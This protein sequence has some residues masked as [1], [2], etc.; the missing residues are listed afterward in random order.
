[1]RA[2]SRSRAA[3]RESVAT[4]AKYRA[5]RVRRSGDPSREIQENTTRADQPRR[6]SGM[7]LFESYPAPAS[8]RRAARRRY[9]ISIS[10]CQ[11]AQLVPATRWRPGF[12]LLPASAEASAGKPPCEGWAVR[13]QAHGCSGTRRACRVRGASALLARQARH[14]AGCL[15]SHDAGRAPIGAP[16]WRF[17]AGV[18]ASFPGIS[19]GSVQRSSSQPSRCAW[20]AGS[21]TSRACGYEPQPRDATP[22]SA[23]RHVSGRR[24][25]MSEAEPSVEDAR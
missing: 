11:T 10:Q 24:P 15:A 3:R 21:R 20:R 22:C 25:S 14:P 4:L 23:F 13:R 16:P 8:M 2:R 17:W 9:E 1:M 12:D 7:T 6:W 18:R 5:V 19:S